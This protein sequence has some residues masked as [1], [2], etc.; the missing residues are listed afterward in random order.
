LSKKASPV[1]RSKDTRPLS[2]NILRNSAEETIPQEKPVE[3]GEP[4]KSVKETMDFLWNPGVIGFQ[5]EK[6][7]T[8]IR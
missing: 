8:L 7:S 4:L 1:K 5:E 6:D 3:A 2:L